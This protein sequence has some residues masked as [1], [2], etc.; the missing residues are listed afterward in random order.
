MYNL[1]D[2]LKN[3]VTTHRS[4][5]ESAENEAVEFERKWKGYYSD[6]VFA[7]KLG[8]ITAKRDTALREGNNAISRNLDSFRNALA[9]HFA[10]KGD[11]LTD[12]AKLLSSGVKLDKRD[13]TIMFDKAKAANNHTMQ[14]LVQRHSLAAGIPIERAYFSEQDLNDAADTISRY[15]RSALPGGVYLSDIWNNAEKFNTIIPD[16]LRDL[17]G[18]EKPYRYTDNS[19]G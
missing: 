18:M 12:D 4:R 1:I 17:Y 16:A 14:E 2:E 13:L 10:L 15:A 7:E 6:G 3:T 5:I 11:E 19:N 8:E 9:E